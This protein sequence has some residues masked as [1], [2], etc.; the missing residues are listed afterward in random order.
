MTVWAKQ[1]MHPTCLHFPDTT[2]PKHQTH[3]DPFTAGHKQ[4]KARAE[5]SPSQKSDVFTKEQNTITYLHNDDR[6]LN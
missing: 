5:K 6:A 3:F 4:F 2:C 1:F